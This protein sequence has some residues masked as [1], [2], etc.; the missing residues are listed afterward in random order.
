MLVMEN[1]NKGRSLSKKSSNI[2]ENNSNWSVQQIQQRE[3]KV[4]K[5]CYKRVG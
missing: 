1:Y 4:S 2:E 5:K 3:T